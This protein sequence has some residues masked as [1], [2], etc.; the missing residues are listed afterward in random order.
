MKRNGIFTIM[1]NLY[2]DVRVHNLPL[3]NVHTFNNLF[4]DI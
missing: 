3:Q 2:Y 4:T 1:D